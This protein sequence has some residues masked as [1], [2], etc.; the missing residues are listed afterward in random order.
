MAFT[1]ARAPMASLFLPPSAPPETPDET[2]RRLTAELHEAYEQQAAATEIL[3]V[4]NSSPGDL[5]PVF[6]AMLETAQP[7]RRRPRIDIPLRRRV[8]PSGGEP[9]PDGGVRHHDATGHRERFAVRS[10]A[11]RWRAFCPYPRLSAYRASE[12]PRSGCRNGKFV[13]RQSLRCIGSGNPAA[14]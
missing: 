4:I 3:Q 12:L 9:W 10:A 7:L 5:A 1:P 8:L 6:D 13:T 14:N 11:D 2:I